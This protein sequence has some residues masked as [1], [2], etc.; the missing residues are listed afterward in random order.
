MQPKIGRALVVGAG[1]SG[2]R[3][4]LDLAE[5]GFRVTLIDRRP[6]LGGVLSQLDY[7]FP[8]NRCG[9][10]KMLPTI[11]RDS[12]SQ[13]CLRKGLFHE[14]IDILLSTRLTSVAGEAGNFTVTL[15]RPSNWVDPA[16]CVGCGLCSSVCP[17]EVPDNFNAGLSRRKAIYLPVPHAIPNPFIIDTAACTRCGACLAVCPTGAITLA[18]D[19]RQSF[20]ILV[21]D[22]ELVVRDSLSEW[23]SF[24][25]FSVA[26]AASGPEAL[27]LLC[28]QSVD[29]MLSDIK[30][31]GMDGVELL[32]LAKE[33]H[34]QLSVIMMT[35]YATIETAVEAMKI[36]AL[37]YLVKPFD[38]DTLIPMVVKAYEA[39]EAGKDRPLAVQTIILSGGTDTAALAAGKNVYGYGANPHVLTSLEFERVLS[40]TGPS[41]GLVLRPFD[42]KPV[43]K[44]AWLQCIGSRD[45][46]SDADYCS[47][48][49][50]MISVKEAL[51]A[52]EKVGCNLTAAIFYMDLRCFEKSF[53][54]YRDF[55][56]N[57]ANVRFERARVHSVTPA[58][59]SGDPQIRFVDQR[60]SVHEET[61]DLVVLATGQ[62][63]AAGSE[64]LARML[65]VTLNPWGFAETRAFSTVA[66]DRP[67]ILVG[68]SFSGLKDISESVIQA[69]AAA[70][71]AQR[72]MHAGSGSLAL[73]QEVESQPPDDLLRQPPRVL[74][75]LCP[76]DQLR[77]A[78][79]DIQAI[80]KALKQDPAVNQVMASGSLCTA[81][82]WE[83]LVK[84]AASASFNRLLIGACHP[85]LFIKKRKQLGDRIGLSPALMEVVDLGRLA[86]EAPAENLDEKSGPG[87][88]E[89]GSMLSAVKAGL[90]RLKKAE[91]GSG[92]RVSVIQKA[93]V[94]GGGVAGL[95]A[96][97]AIADM[98]YPV[99]VVEKA[100]RLGGNL[101]WLGKTLEGNSV[102]DLLETTVARVEKHPRIRIHK[103]A[104]ILDSIGQ[105]GSFSTRIEDGE[106]IGHTIDHGAAILA[107]GGTE[108]KTSAYGFGQS[109]KIITQKEL[110]QKAADGSLYS[111]KLDTVVM[112]QCVESREVPR[113]YCSRVCCSAALKHAL[114]LKEKRPDIQVY[115]AY[116]D[117]MSYGFAETYFT[118]A[119]RAGVVFIPYDTERKPQVAVS[120][121][122]PAE[123]VAVTVFDPI[124]GAELG[125]D[126]DLLVLATGIVSRLDQALAEAFGVGRDENGFF[127]EA[128]SKWRPVD[129]LKEGVFACGLAHSPRNIAESIA[130]AQAAA[131]RALRILCRPQLSVDKIVAK[132]RESLC[133]LCERCIE[134]CPY[135]ARTIDADLSKILV[136]PVMCQGCGTCAA[137][138]PNGA[139]I[140]QGF[141]RQQVLAEIDAVF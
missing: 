81:Q 113:N 131:Q 30:M 128:E 8:S 56:Q 109:P 110:E 117:M 15:R 129:S 65:G 108:A 25:G 11:Q 141:S 52:R 97:L 60:G 31:P 67:G 121:D 93:L 134:A 89:T 140:I 100:D 84:A 3:S 45:L 35:A 16:L 101:T 135:G 120:Q 26:M 18:V 19:Q 118:A 106:G 62:R 23:L 27:Q 82:G 102:S 42:A 2:I 9:M 133:A 98:G 112:I 103:N 94:V 53:Q 122:D 91:P 80:S 116:R 59:G 73:T 1:I 138:C 90:E 87:S 72:V 77:A 132:V 54:S 127:K 55:A 49:C 10:C 12:G 99:D 5:T 105:V 43:G 125:I 69:S 36:G 64:E 139:A 51:L 6:S 17:V 13:F 14:N 66:T 88:W 119:R 111:G 85:Y 61:F 123:G 76:C 136:N 92:L 47:S 40:G 107:V 21:V 115:I 96:A 57:G 4:A 58:A 22:D 50:C 78:K 124:L 137:V 83:E 86:P 7:Q 126:A 39:L 95:T 63:P 29:L 75:A 104:R 70:L 28:E 20:R 34:P 79:L 37:D 48:I 114:L 68:G 130:T 24:E 46:Q 74:V 44:I 71:E 38:P 32:K 33:A 41:Q